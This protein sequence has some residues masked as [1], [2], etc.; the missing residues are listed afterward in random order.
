MS[1]KSHESVF[2]LLVLRVGMIDGFKECRVDSRL[3]PS[4]WETSLQSNAVS[5]WL[6]AN[7]ESVLE[8]RKKM[9]IVTKIPIK[10]TVFESTIFK[11]AANMIGTVNT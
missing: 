8:W 7:L 1:T 2:L 4:Q 9:Q 11:L 10:E 6:D 5:R 3:A